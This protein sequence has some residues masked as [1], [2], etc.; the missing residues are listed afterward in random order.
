MYTGFG[1]WDN[2]KIIHLRTL[3]I[4]YWILCFKRSLGF[5]GSS[6]PPWN[7]YSSLPSLLPPSSPA[8]II[9]LCGNQESLPFLWPLKR[10]TRRATVR[11]LWL[12]FTL[13]YTPAAVLVPSVLLQPNSV[14]ILPPTMGRWGDDNDFCGEH[15][16]ISREFI[17]C[18]RG[19]SPG[20]GT[21]TGRGEAAEEQ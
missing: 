21:R 13:L 9:F 6:R 11:R 10:H 4:I 2:K 5:L 14:L 18:R 17:Q 15:N 3:S 12:I 20:S 8:V 1:P 7:F 19:A 16:K